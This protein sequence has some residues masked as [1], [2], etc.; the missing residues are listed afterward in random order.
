MVPTAGQAKEGE[1]KGGTGGTG[2]DKKIKQTI[3]RIKKNRVAVG[4]T[5]QK[6]QYNVSIDLSRLKESNFVINDAISGM[7]ENELKLTKSYISFLQERLSLWIFKIQFTEIFDDNNRKVAPDKITTLML[8]FVQENLKKLCPKQFDVMSFFHYLQFF[9]KISFQKKYMYKHKNV[10]MKHQQIKQWTKTNWKFYRKCFKKAMENIQALVSKYVIQ[11]IKGYV[12]ITMQVSIY[13]PMF[14]VI[15]F[16]EYS[17]SQKLWHIWQVQDL[18]IL[19][20]NKMSTNGDLFDCGI[21]AIYIVENL[22]I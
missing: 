1:E 16:M 13:H 17:N 4:R 11:I 14:V 6:K 9:F 10:C 2:D 12:N 15:P 18:G 19:F 21:T 22:P 7:D 3:K 8:W 5:R 20:N